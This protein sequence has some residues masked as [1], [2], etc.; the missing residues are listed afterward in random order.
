MQSLRIEKL[1]G[2]QIH[3][4]LSEL[5]NLRMKIFREYPYL[6]EG[7]IDYEKKYLQTYLDS[8]NSNLILAID[9]TENKIVGASTAIPLADETSEVQQ[10]FLKANMDISSIF[11][12]GESVLLPAY[13]GKNIYRHFFLEREK[14]A[15]EHGCTVAV[16]CGVKREENHPLKPVGYKPLDKVW[17]RFGFKKHEHLH[18]Q[19]EWKDLTE[20]YPSLK[21][22]IFWLKSLS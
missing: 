2:E 9:S 5:A 7:H 3:P 20:S 22:M 10:P 13:R 17:Q 8:Q 14:A 21:S 19:Y 12:F 6:Y 15:R 16:F 18:A 4:Y 11:Y 1:S